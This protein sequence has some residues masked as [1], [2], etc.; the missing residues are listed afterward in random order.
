MS[1]NI[2]ESIPTSADPRSKR[3]IKK[4]ALTPG[5]KLAADVEALFAK[6]DREIHIPGA[7]LDKGLAPPPEI[8]ANVQGSSAGAGSGEFHVYKASR[9]REYERLRMMDE[10]VKK[11]EDEKEF[12]K[13][14]DELERKDREKTEKNR[15]KREKA[16]AR[17]AKQRSG[18]K[19]G[20]SG[21]DGSPASEGD[22]LKKKLVPKSN[23]PKP[24]DEEEDQV[25]NGGGEVKNSEE[26]GLIIEDD[27]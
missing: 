8:V 4:R 17:K 7:K 10:Q 27:D 18:Q 16:R 5:G 14:K 23:A 2:P 9:R 12:Q 21:K 3:P 19:D 6:P 13:R 1:E 20:A 11:E 24:A 26:I 15:A 22:K 25:L